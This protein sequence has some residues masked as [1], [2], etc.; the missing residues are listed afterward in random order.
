[1][2][3]GHSVKRG[4]FKGESNDQKIK[5][6]KVLD[7]LALSGAE[8]DDVIIAYGGN[9]TAI[10]QD[11]EDDLSGGA[12][13][14]LL[15]GA[16][17]DD[18]VADGMVAAGD[19]FT[20]DDFSDDF[21]A[22]ETF[23]DNGSDTI[24]MYDSNAT[25]SDGGTEGVVDIIDLGDAIDFVDTDGMNGIEDSEKLAQLDAAFSYDSATGA[26]ADGSANTWFT[27]YADAG[28]TFADTV[29]VEVDGDQFMWD[30]ANWA[31]I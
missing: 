29:Y 17:W 14:D 31:L 18:T 7:D 4:G 3:N 22:E 8:G 23:E 25:T 21:N 11:G 15:I 26:L 13:D 16:I 30:G 27:V 10:G 9:D 2:A 24:W 19:T 5:G 12:G 1:M 20:Q 28:A 6:D